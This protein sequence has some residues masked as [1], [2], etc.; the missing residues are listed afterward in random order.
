ML[1]SRFLTNLQR[2]QGRSMDDTCTLIAVA[3]GAANDYGYPEESSSETENVACGFEW[4]KTDE[5]GGVQQVPQYDAKLRLALG[6]ALDGISKVRLTK[7]QG[8]ALSPALL[9]DVVGEPMPGPTC[10]V[11]RLR[12]ITDE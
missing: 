12:S 6:T 3:D 9:F 2:Q 4:V 1:K 8:E 7:L 11:S 10:L 5:L